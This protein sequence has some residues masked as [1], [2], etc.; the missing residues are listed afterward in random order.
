MNTR[1][2]VRYN[3]LLYQLFI[4]L[5]SYSIIS[6]YFDYRNPVFFGGDVCR[7]R[8]GRTLGVGTGRKRSGT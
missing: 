1:L 8:I 7:L 4:T 3:L 5:D 2:L 6:Q